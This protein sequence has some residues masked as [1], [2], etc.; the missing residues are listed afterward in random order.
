MNRHLCCAAAVLLAAASAGAQE[1]GWPSSVVCA[2]GVP[3]ICTE[4]RCRPASL[5][6]LDVPSMVRL[7]LQ[8]GTMHA[9][10]PEHLGRTS[11]FKVIERSETRM[12]MQGFENGRA[13][14]AML[15][16]DGTLAISATTQATNFSVFARCANLQVVNEVGK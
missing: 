8:T 6:A 15:F 9:V 16:E 10:N 13:F 7:D 5:D 11:R 1:L 14:S 12:V 2:L 3:T 4:E